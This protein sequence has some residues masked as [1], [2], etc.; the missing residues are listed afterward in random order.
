MMTVCRRY[1]ELDKSIK[2]IESLYSEFK[3]K[4]DIVV[5]W[6][7]PEL[8]RLWYF[9]DLLKNKRIAH[10]VYRESTTKDGLTEGPTTYGAS[11]N[12]RK[13]LDFIKSTYKPPFYV[14]CNDADISVEPG[15]FKWIDKE[16]EGSIEGVLFFWQNHI[17]NENAWHTNFFVISDNENYWPPVS[18]V[19]S[20]DVLECQWGDN[21]ANLGLGNILRSHNSRNQK[22]LH[23]HES[24]RLPQFQ[25][26]PQQDSLG[27]SLFIKGYIPWY[28]RLGRFI[29]GLFNG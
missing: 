10:L 18:S 21:L 17:R 1:H 20:P 16:M 5:V 11:L 27:V 2:H 13:G 12:I 26:K 14:I 15:H 23:I 6:A 9:Q 29:R 7:A 25:W 19:D 28:I 4:P 22:F 8:G 3:E 24:E